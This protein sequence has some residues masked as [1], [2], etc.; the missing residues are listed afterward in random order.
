MDKITNNSV[1]KKKKIE[2]TV[3]YY[4]KKKLNFGKKK[5]LNR[6]MFKI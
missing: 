2:F 1:G 5:N 4:A 3:K 6:I